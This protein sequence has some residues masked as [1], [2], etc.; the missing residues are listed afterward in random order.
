MI[1]SLEVVIYCQQ[2]REIVKSNV[3]FPCMYKAQA[4]APHPTSTSAKLCSFCDVL[5]AYLT[6]FV[7]MDVFHKIKSSPFNSN[8]Q[9]KGLSTNSFVTPSGFQMGLGNCASYFGSLL[10][11]NQRL[12][13]L[14]LSCLLLRV[15]KSR[16][17]H[18]NISG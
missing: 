16:F 3:Y 8:L 6:A 2:F 10:N 14:F 1:I 12:Q 15:N 17:S 11:K 5:K 4:V 13:A 7:I 9:T 18:A